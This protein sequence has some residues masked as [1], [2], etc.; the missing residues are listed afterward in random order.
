MMDFPMC[1]YLIANFQIGLSF[2]FLH[3]KSNDDMRQFW[4]AFTVGAF[5]IIMLFIGVL[6]AY[7]FQVLDQPGLSG[8]IL[9]PF[10]ND[11]TSTARI[12]RLIYQSIIIAVAFFIGVSEVIL[13]TSLYKKTSEMI[14]SERILVLAVAASVGIM[15]DAV[16]FLIY[17]IVDEP[18]PYFSIVLLFT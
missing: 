15:S 4:S 7:R 13:G 1:L 17:Y 6:L 9:C 2:F 14:G 5:L 18:H 3:L 12:I 11:T 8:P 16:A 10:Y